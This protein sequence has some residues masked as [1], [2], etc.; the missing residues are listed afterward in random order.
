MLRETDKTLPEG[1]SE[2]VIE[3]SDQQTTTGTG[4]PGGSA[5]RSA[6]T[7]SLAGSPNPAALQQ[8]GATVV[9]RST[10]QE[11]ASVIVNPESGIISVRASSRQHENIQE[12]LDQIMAAAR[13]QVLIEATIAEVQL[14]DEFRQGV[15][16][17]ALPL[18][19]AGFSLKQTVAGDLGSESASMLELSYANAASRVG[20]IRGTISL[21]ESFGTVKILSSP[22][23]SVLN[24]QSAVLKVIDNQVYFTIKADTTQ[25]QTSTVT[26][27][28]T[29]LNSVPVGLVMNVTPQIGDQD[30]VLLNVRPSISRIVGRVA[31]PN[32]ALAAANITSTIPIIR[33][34]EMESMIR[35]ES[36]NIAVM[37]GLMEDSLQHIDDQLPGLAGIPFFGKLF[38]NQDH[39]GQKTELIV[40]LRPLVLH[41]ASLDGDFHHLS[42]LFHP[43]WPQ[44]RRHGAMS[45]LMDALKHGEAAKRQVGSSTDLRLQTTADRLES[46]ERQYFPAAPRSGRAGKGVVA[47]QAPAAGRQALLL[48]AAVFSLLALSCIGIYCWQHWL[49]RS[50]LLERPTATPLPTARAALAPIPPMTPASPPVADSAH[51]VRPAQK[52]AAPSPV[53]DENNAIRL[54]HGGLV[55]TL[56]PALSRGYE[57]YQG[58]DPGAARIAYQQALNQDPYSLDALRGLGAIALHDRQN[59]E[60]DHYFRRALVVEPRDAVARAGLAL[61]GDAEDRSESRL[62]SLLA[63]QPGSPQLNFALGNLLAGRQR[64][65]EAQQA[66]FRAMTAAPGEPDILFNLAVSLDHLHQAKLAAEHYRQAIRAA[67]GHAHRFEPGRAAARIQA[68]QP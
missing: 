2:T 4:A 6:P 55:L 8:E 18:G 51:A 7:T 52:L 28:T 46:L 29:T 45:L 3:K 57:L 15:N 24:N 5:R 50:G 43:G 14:S 37:G 20:N 35:I 65:A 60:A 17:S 22:K 53:S 47:T 54:N 62:R 42:R 59:E 26:S 30:T 64:W 41:D 13:R 10:F 63:E 66:Y 40:F 36:G 67:A 33:T 68:L 61:L 19:R 49:A 48:S 12:F 39:R 21:L 27:Y 58:G 1:S 32:P 34:R 16:W 9:R 25:N 31:D 56:D 44:R 38:Q 11:A 23:L